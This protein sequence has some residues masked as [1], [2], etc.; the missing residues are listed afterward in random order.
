MIKE[1]LGV[2]QGKSQCLFTLF[3]KNK[4]LKLILV[5]EMPKDNLI[6][7]IVSVNSIIFF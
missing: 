6:L 3:L 5:M 7:S 4:Q 2:G 1:N